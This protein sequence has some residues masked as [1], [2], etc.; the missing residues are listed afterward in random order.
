MCELS[1]KNKCSERQHC[2]NCWGVLNSRCVE[3]Y[4]ENPTHSVGSCRKSVCLVT[5]VGLMCFL[6]LAVFTGSTLFST[7]ITHNSLK[8]PPKPDARLLKMVIRKLT[9]PGCDIEIFRQLY[10]AF[11][12]GEQ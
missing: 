9:I 11:S 12:M 6:F 8:V 10:F 4:C 7:S 2:V 1:N 5:L 3:N